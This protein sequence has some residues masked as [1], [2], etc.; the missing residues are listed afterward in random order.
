YRVRSGDSL[1]SIASRFRVTI[2]DIRKWNPKD[3]RNK[4]L[5]PGQKLLLHVNVVH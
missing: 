1:A 2:A 3:T 5:Y 4:Y